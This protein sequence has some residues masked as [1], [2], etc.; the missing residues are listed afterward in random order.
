MVF[1]SPIFL[2]LYLPMVLM[3]HAVCP[4]AAR[5]VLLLVASFVFYAWGEP[6][7]VP[8][9]LGVLAL[10]WALGWA[11]GAAPVRWRPAFVALA[12]GLNLG[13]LGMYKY[14]AWLVANLNSVLVALGGAPLPVPRGAVVIGLSFITFQALSYVIDVACRE[15]AFQRNPLTLALYLV[16]FPQLIAGPIVRYHDIA[17]QLAHR[18]LTRSEFAL[19]VQR[20]ILGLGKKVLIANPLAVPA[21][22]IFA[23]PASARRA[24][25]RTSW[26][27]S[28][29]AGCGTGRAGPLSCG[30]CTMACSW[31]WSAW[32]SAGSSPACRP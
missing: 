20:F 25:T 3:L 29:S 26:S 5:N 23:L 21:D 13:L 27:C 30:A 4:P 12:V 18:R 11:V 24:S 2:F 1:S 10:N 9:L 6:A 16:L 15:A 17:G 28:C 8:V 31:F 7:F 14:G 19:G 32:A 22:A